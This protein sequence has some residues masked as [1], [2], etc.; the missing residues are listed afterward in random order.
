MIYIHPDSTS[1]HL[2]EI[3]CSLILASMTG[4]FFEANWTCECFPQVAAQLPTVR[5]RAN[6]LNHLVLFF[7]LT[8][9]LNLLLRYLILSSIAAILGNYWN[10]SAFLVA[11]KKFLAKTHAD[12]CEHGAL[13]RTRNCDFTALLRYWVCEKSDWIWEEIVQKIKKRN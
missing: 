11:S 13:L 6:T 10:C 12:V 2:K 4:R 8:L 1:G 5:W 3:I 7:A 9:T